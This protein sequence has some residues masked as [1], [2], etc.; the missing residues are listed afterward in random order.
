MGM[1]GLDPAG[2]QQLVDPAPIDDGPELASDLPLP[3]RSLVVEQPARDD[4][5]AFFGVTFEPQ[6][7]NAAVARSVSAGSPADQ[8]GVLAGDTIIALNGTK[9]ATYDDV[10]QT[11][12]RLKPG[13]VLDVEISRRVSVRARAVLEGSPLGV[14]HTSG[15]RGEAESLPTPAGYQVAPPVNQI[16]GNRAQSNNNS[17]RP[18]QGYGA[19]QNR[20]TNVNRDGNSNRTNNSNDRNRD[21]RGRGMFRRR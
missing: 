3:E 1:V 9:T 18:R 10:L 17:P 11:I 14:E 7:R 21:N 6:V 5:R 8:A 13:D 15:Y 12:A 16:P 20:N 2:A 4:S 19:P